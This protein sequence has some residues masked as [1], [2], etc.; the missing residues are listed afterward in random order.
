MN[1]KKKKDNTRYC[2]IL[3]SKVKT[4]EHVT[5]A[6][7]YK[8]PIKLVPERTTFCSEVLIFHSMLLNT[9]LQEM[10]TS[11]HIFLEQKTKFNH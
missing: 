1:K 5:L 3:Q 6:Q 8:N 2:Q 10:E 11:L 4:Y 7:L 9:Q